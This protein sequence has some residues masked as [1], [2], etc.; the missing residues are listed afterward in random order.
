MR[1][2]KVV[3]NGIEYQTYVIEYNNVEFEVGSHELAM[4]VDIADEKGYYF[5]DD[6]AFFDGAWG[7]IE[8]FD[9]DVYC[10]LSKHYDNPTYS[11]IVNDVKPILDE[12]FD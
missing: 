1:T 9:C 2:N 12:Y 6:I 8:D 7:S 10:Y 3:I 11:D 5:D 4:A